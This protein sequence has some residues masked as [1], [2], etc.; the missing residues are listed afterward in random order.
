MA[1]SFEWCHG[2]MPSLVFIWMLGFLHCFRARRRDESQTVFRMDSCSPG[3]RSFSMMFPEGEWASSEASRSA[4]SFPAMPVWLGIQ[5]RVA[6][7]PLDFRQPSRFL[8]SPTHLFFGGCDET[9]ALMDALES[10]K[11]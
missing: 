7:V 10:E 3:D 11:M 8:I 9:M 1:R 2:M 6:I 4:S 5:Y